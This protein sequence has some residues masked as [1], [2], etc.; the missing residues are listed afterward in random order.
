LRFIGKS[1]K[2]L[3]A[4][5][6]TQFHV[7]DNAGCEGLLFG[8]GGSFRR[9]LALVPALRQRVAQRKMQAALPALPLF[10]ELLGF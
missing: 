7:R 8:G 6:T 9:I 1:L 10:H 2:K 3:N 5:G 4:A